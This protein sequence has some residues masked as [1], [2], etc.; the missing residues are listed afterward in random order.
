M[1]FS[2]VARPDIA[3]GMSGRATQDVKRFICSAV[4]AW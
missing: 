4:R 1:S 3:A 2:L